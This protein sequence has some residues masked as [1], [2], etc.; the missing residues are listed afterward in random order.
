MHTES[1]A[2]YRRSREQSEGFDGPNLSVSSEERNGI[3]EIIEAARLGCKLR[4]FLSFSKTQAIITRQLRVR[5]VDV[6]FEFGK[7]LSGKIYYIARKYLHTVEIKFCL[8]LY[9]LDIATR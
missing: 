9:A 7:N 4:P 8:K 1:P 3:R 2:G 6:S 5:I